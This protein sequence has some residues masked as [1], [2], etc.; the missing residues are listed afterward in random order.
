MPGELDDFYQGLALSHGEPER[1]LK[2]RF[3]ALLQRLV[4][5]AC[6][7]FHDLMADRLLGT[8]RRQRWFKARARRAEPTARSSENV[9]IGEMERE[10]LLVGLN[11]TSVE[12]DLVEA[13]EHRIPLPIWAAEQNM[14]LSEARKLL[15][16]LRLR[17]RDITS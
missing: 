13:L 3:P 5:S 17:A 12:M 9:V 15:N 14:P 7:K 10:R 16:R 4:S 8:A 2:Q 1:T 6:Q 11:L